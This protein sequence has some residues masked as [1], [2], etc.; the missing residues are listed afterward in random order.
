M[1]DWLVESSC[2]GAKSRHLIC[3]HGTTTRQL[4]AFPYSRLRTVAVDSEAR[5]F[6]ILTCSLV[7]TQHFIDPAYALWDVS[8]NMDTALTVVQVSCVRVPSVLRTSNLPLF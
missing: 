1:S 5:Q 4:P 7:I 3:Q 6:T 8:F 2:E